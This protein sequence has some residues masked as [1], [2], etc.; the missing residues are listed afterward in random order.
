MLKIEPKPC[1][2]VTTHR[3][4]IHLDKSYEVVIDKVV[5]NEGHTYVIQSELEGIEKRIVEAAVL[6]EVNKHGIK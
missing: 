1:V 2:T 3:A 4:T 6:N 5:T